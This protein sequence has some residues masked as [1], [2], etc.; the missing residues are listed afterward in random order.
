MPVDSSAA[1]IA[2]VP[3][4]YFL[5]CLRCRENQGMYASKVTLK[6][7]YRKLCAKNNN[8]VLEK[9]QGDAWQGVYPSYWS[10]PVGGPVARID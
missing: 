1:G 7:T 8:I 6:H 10:P 4:E 9:V 2:V 5:R 3:A